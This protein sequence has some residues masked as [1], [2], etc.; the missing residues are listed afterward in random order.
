MEDK[1]IPINH[2]LDD[3]GRFNIPLRTKKLLYYSKEQP[4]N[5]GLSV[6][7]TLSLDIMLNNH[8]LLMK[9]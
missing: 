5:V 4:K 6:S 2:F 3:R 7:L 9:L 1:L 8:Q